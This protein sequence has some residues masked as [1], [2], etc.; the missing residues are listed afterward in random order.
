MSH[1][2]SLRTDPVKL[3]IG[4]YTQCTVD[5]ATTASWLDNNYFNEH[6]HLC[7]HLMLESVSMWDFAVT[8]I[9]EARACTHHG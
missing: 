4:V 7:S 5:S 1:R 9:L 3:M 2:I 6:A 8:N